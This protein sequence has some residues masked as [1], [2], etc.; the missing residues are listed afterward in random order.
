MFEI[1]F[2]ADEELMELIRWLKSHLSLKHPKGASFLEIFKYAMN[3]VRESEDLRTAAYEQIST[4]RVVGHRPICD[5][6]TSVRSARFLAREIMSSADSR[7]SI[8]A[9][10]R[11]ITVW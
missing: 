1:R 8:L 10:Y 6:N 7:S 4:K 5:F 11:S 2:A 9:W 3:Y